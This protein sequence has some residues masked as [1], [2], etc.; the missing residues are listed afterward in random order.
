MSGIH[1]LQRIS[2]K[3]VSNQIVSLTERISKLQKNQAVK[4]NQIIELCNK[5]EN[6]NAIIETKISIP[7]KN[8]N[9]LSEKITKAQSNNSYSHKKEEENDRISYDDAEE[10][11]EYQLPEKKKY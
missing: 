2:N 6:F 4:S 1:I 7:N 3:S 5:L 11:F 8:I 9:K 10:D